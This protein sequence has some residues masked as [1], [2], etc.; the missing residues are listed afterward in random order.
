MALSDASRPDPQDGMRPDL[1]GE[2]PAGESTLDPE[3]GMNDATGADGALTNG[4]VARVD[5]P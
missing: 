5:D 1:L 2:D 3:I 4:R